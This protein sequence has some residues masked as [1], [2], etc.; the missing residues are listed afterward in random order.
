MLSVGILCVIGAAILDIVANLVLDKSKGFTIKKWGFLA[1]FLV[2]IAFYLLSLALKEMP[3]SIAYTLWGS[4][5]ILGTAL[6]GH[7]FLGQKLKPIGW[8]GILVIISAVI[9][10]KTA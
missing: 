8:V 3:L 4:I 9:V 7:Y 1:L 2:W 6:G 10:L 5:G